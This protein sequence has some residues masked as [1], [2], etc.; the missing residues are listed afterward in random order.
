MSESRHEVLLVDDDADIIAVWRKA[1]AR[2]G[3]QVT[4]AASAEAALGPVQ[5]QAFDAA[6]VDLVLPGRGGMEVVASVRAADPT[7]VVIIVTGYASLDSA[8]EAVR[9]GAFD[10]LRKPVDTAELLDTVARGLEARELIA[11]NH[12]LLRGLDQANREMR[13]AQR[14]LTERVQ[15]LQHHIDALVELGKRLS[16]IHAPQAIMQQLLEAA[17][18]LTGAQAGAILQADRSLNQLRVIVCT[19]IDRREVCDE[20]L[21]LGQGILG[22]VA[23]SGERCV[24]NDLLADAAL[25]EDALVYAGMR[26]VVAH[27]LVAGGDVVGVIALFDARNQPFAAEEQDLIAMLAVQAGTLLTATGLVR[28]RPPQA[29]APA[30]DE[31]IDLENLLSNR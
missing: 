12:R 7:T 19:G 18:K 22:Q 5:R 25:A 14:S 6:I 28:P 11:H 29:G 20:G 8:I 27:P 24:V 17:L 10:Y 9:R 30:P 15:E 26:R 23:E 1:F 13:I 4:T 21:P 16:R 2:Q 3:Y 31:F